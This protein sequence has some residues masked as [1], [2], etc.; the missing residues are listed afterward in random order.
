MTSRRRN[1]Q[2]FQLLII[3]FA[4][5]SCQSNLLTGNKSE[6]WKIE[7]RVSHSNNGGD[8]ELLLAS[9]GQ[10]VARNKSSNVQTS[11]RAS[12]ALV[13]KVQAF[14]QDVS[15]RW[16]GA[17]TPVETSATRFISSTVWVGNRPLPVEIPKDLDDLL[18][19]ALMDTLSS[20][21]RIPLDLGRVWRIEEGFIG[22]ETD[23]EGVWTRRG[24][25]NIFDARWRNCWLNKLQSDVIEV[26][27]AQNGEVTLLRRGLNKRYRGKYSLDK[28]TRISG[29]ADWYTPG[30]IWSAR[31]EL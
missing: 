9:D 10:L 6:E 18:F 7:Y 14:V 20:V 23:W 11:K 12:M 27:V 26:E 19:K 2:R 29:T 22:D 25:S 1:L 17:E 24:Q 15:A 8:K 5:G 28:P 31:I 16:Q 13:R 30:V 4:C 21:Q 3:L